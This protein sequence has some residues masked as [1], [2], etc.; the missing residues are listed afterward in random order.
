M[1]CVKETSEAK[2]RLDGFTANAL[3][4]FAPQRRRSIRDHDKTGSRKMRRNMNTLNEMKQM[5]A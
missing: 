4:Q 5:D 1:K 3:K 2:L